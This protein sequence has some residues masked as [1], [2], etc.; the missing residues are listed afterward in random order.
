MRCP[1]WAPATLIFG[2]QQE[3]E[4]VM[5][6]RTVITSQC[7]FFLFCLVLVVFTLLSCSAKV[8]HSSTY[9]RGRQVFV[10]GSR[11]PF[12]DTVTG[13]AREGYR[14]EICT[15]EKRYRNGSLHGVTRYWYPSGQLESK[16][17][18]ADGQINGVVTRYH[19]NG[20]IK[21]RLHFVNG[22]R[23]GSKGEM[24]WGADGKRIK[25]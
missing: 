20:R 5:P 14:R 16:V 4:V 10:V 15:F 2:L 21:A 13:R 17:P 24:F 11:A 9:R 19:H 18:Y 12:T 8:D 1:P 25:D 6:T 23:G 7:L 3:I 22:M